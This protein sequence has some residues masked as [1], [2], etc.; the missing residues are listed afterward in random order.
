[1]SNFVIWD[2]SFVSHTPLP[3][4]EYFFV[5]FKRYAI[6]KLWRFG[7]TDSALAQISLLRLNCAGRIN[8]FVA[9]RLVIL[10][11]KHLDSNQTKRSVSLSAK[12]GPFINGIN[13]SDSLRRETS[14]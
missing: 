4:L 13:A 3:S 7:C 10:E 2:E 1:M 9:V 14:I 12:I 8:R 11:T 6:F 5:L